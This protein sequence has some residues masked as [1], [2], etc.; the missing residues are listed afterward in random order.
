[1]DA[2]DRIGDR[3]DHP[4]L[5]PPGLRHLIPDDQQRVSRVLGIPMDDSL[6]D[7][8]CS[9]GAIAARL[10]DRYGLRAYGVEP[11]E[12]YWQAN[13]RPQ[14]RMMYRDVGEVRPECFHTVL[15]GELFEHLDA[16][17]GD[18][19]LRDATA[20]L[21]ADGQLIVTVPN[22]TP[23]YDYVR[24]R[25]SRWAWPDHRRTFTQPQLARFLGK[26]FEY[27]AFVPLYDVNPA[28]E[29]E[30][31]DESI[32]LIARARGKRC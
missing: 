1:M 31:P 6:L 18:A 9:D 28:G 19:L 22:R 23:H 3:L 32:F 14:I 24:A 7:V 27:V 29:P 4:E 16:A 12:S 2:T 8:G 13:D 30:T 5:V 17:N 20:A 10:A 26:R 15:V 25:R 11:G 21:K